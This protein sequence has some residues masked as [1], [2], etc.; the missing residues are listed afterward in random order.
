MIGTPPVV[1]TQGRDGGT[2]TTRGK[3]AGTAIAATDTGTETTDQVATTEGKY[4]SK[5]IL[6]I[7]IV[8]ILIRRTRVTTGTSTD[9]EKE[10]VIPPAID[11][12]DD[13]D[14]HHPMTLIGET[15]ETREIEKA[16]LTERT[17]NGQRSCTRT[18]KSVSSPQIRLSTHKATS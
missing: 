15:G 4:P 13:R 7:I 14:G 5:Y 9:A 2:E 10:T 18:S 16:D 3:D 12:I 1:T 8:D 6:L 17:L 11:T